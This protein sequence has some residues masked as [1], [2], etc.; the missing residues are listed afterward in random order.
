[1]L[2]C[3]TTEKNY[4]V[5]ALAYLFE[6][7]REYC[8]AR[9]EPLTKKI[10]FKNDYSKKTAV[11]NTITNYQT[12][13]NGTEILD[14]YQDI[15]KKNTVKFKRIDTLYRKLRDFRN[16]L[17]HINKSKD[18]ADIKKNISDMIV[19]TESIYKDDILANIKI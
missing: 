3:M 18:F 13:H 4:L 9:F 10:K 8:S 1:M 6:S 15:Y 2:S 5:V 19:K 16:D 11:M 17:A 14:K 7:F 12:A